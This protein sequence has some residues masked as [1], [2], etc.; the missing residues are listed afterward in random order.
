MNHVTGMKVV[1]ASQSMEYA[2]DNT[3]LIVLRDFQ[4]NGEVNETTVALTERHPL[5]V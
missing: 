1:E 4:V 2:A 3:S 5:S